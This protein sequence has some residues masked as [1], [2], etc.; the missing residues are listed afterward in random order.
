MEKI[1]KIGA[2]LLAFSFF[3]Q[4]CNAQITYTGN[5]LNIGN[6]ISPKEG[7]IN[8][9]DVSSAV[10]RHENTFIRYDFTDTAPYMSGS[11][12]MVGVCCTAYGPMFQNFTCSS[13]W[14]VYEPTS[15]NSKNFE[16]GTTLK[17]LVNVKVATTSENIRGEERQMT[18]ALDSKSLRE[19]FPE[20]VNMESDG[21]ESIDFSSLVK[22]LYSS[23]VELENRLENQKSKLAEL[24]QLKE[25]YL[26][27]TD[28]R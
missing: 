19:T 5:Q 14:E 22:I 6:V 13:I 15:N 12:G 2:L 28:I 17:K 1:I 9:S 16:I 21:S 26:Q 10:F 18:T 27:I 4:G 25:T 24:Q 11:C 3:R 20:V 23:L 7:L 8:I